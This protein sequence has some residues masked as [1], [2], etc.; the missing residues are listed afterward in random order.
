MNKYNLRILEAKLQKISQITA[1]ISLS[2]NVVQTPVNLGERNH[3][4]L[5]QLPLLSFKMMSVKI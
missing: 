5:P 4:K 2:L 1:D 3:L